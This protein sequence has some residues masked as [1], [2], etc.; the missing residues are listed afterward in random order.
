MVQDRL[1]QADAVPQFLLNA[2]RLPDPEVGG[3]ELR[4][5]DVLD[6]ALVEAKAEFPDQ[7]LVLARVMESIGETY[8]G[9]GWFEKAAMTFVEVEGVIEGIPGGDEIRKTIH[10]ALSETYRLLAEQEK[11]VEASAEYLRVSIEYFGNSS[12][13]ARKARHELVLNLIE[14]GEIDRAEEV[15]LEARSLEDPEEKPK[16]GDFDGLEALIHEARGRY[17]EAIDFYEERLLAHFSSDNRYGHNEMWGLRH[18]T[19][20]CRKRGDLE[21]AIAFSEELFR[22]C[23]IS[24]GKGHRYVVDA[25]SHLALSYLGGGDTAVAALVFDRL[26]RQAES[27]GITPD[28][29]SLLRQFRDMSGLELAM[30]D[31]DRANMSSISDDMAWWIAEFDYTEGKTREALVTMERLIPTGSFEKS[32]ELKKFGRFSRLMIALME[33]GEYGKVLKYLTEALESPK[34]DHMLAASIPSVTYQFLEL[35]CFNGTL[36]GNPG[37]AEKVFSLAARQPIKKSACMYKAYEAIRK[38]FL[39]Q[40]GEKDLVAFEQEMIRRFAE[41]LPRNQHTLIQ[42]KLVLAEILTNRKR[43]EEAVI[44]LEDIMASL[45]EGKPWYSRQLVATY[46][47]FGRVYRRQGQFKEA[48]MALRNASESTKLVLEVDT[49][50]WEKNSERWIEKIE[51]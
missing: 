21:K 17:Q 38:D 20:I 24:Y 1:T 43:F 9:L 4:A 41:A 13:E 45:E 10:Q 34:R 37:M 49:Q 14:I 31:L 51:N 27:R 23:E 46:F 39:A 48:G 8:R 50:W 29:Q 42:R 36:E 25:A 2:F 16:G 35:V 19:R 12:V 40:D 47:H 44:V 3:T 15:I 22:C 32:D 18:V 7:P 28:D 11:A 5:V 30:S 33:N 26:E 6:A